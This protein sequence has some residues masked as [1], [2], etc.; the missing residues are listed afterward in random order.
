MTCRQIV[1]CTGGADVAYEVIQHE[2]LSSIAQKFG[3]T[4]AELV[5]LNPT[6]IPTDF[7]EGQIICVP[8]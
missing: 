2:T 3:I 7:T 5:I 6:L 8:A 4:E 1:D